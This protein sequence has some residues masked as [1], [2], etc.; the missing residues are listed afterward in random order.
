MA[1]LWRITLKRSYIGA[2]EKQRATLKA[3][4]LRRLHQTVEK[5]ATPAVKGMVE[6]VRHLVEVEEV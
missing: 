6:A 2:N 5:E 1:K 4:G 3:L